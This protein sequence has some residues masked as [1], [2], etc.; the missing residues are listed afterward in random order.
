MRFSQKIT[1]KNKMKSKKKSTL[2]FSQTKNRS[3]ET[4]KTKKIGNLIYEIEKFLA[5]KVEN[6][7]FSTKYILSEILQIPV[8][9]L[10]FQ[11]EKTVSQQ[12]IKKIISAA[13]RRSKD[14]PLQYI[15]GKAYFRNLILKVGSG[16]LIPRPE[17][18]LMVDE[19]LSA[20]PQ[21]GTFCDIGTGS[22]AI[23]LS[24]AS[25]RPD[26]K[27]FAS[28]ISTNALKY[29]RYNRKKLKLKNVFIRQGSLFNPFKN[30]E[31]DVI[32][33]NLPYIKN[34]DIPKLPCEI[35]KFEPESAL[36]G[37]EDG[38]DLIRQFFI[39]AIAHSK[40][41]TFIIAEI[42]PEQ[43]RAIKS[44]LKKIPQYSNL[45]IIKDLNDQN[46]FISIC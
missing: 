35:R 3:L 11:A 39:D 20:L 37:G 8:P 14:E 44:F 12:N 21:G 23:A 2:R 34:S 27:V 18:E 9:E 10:D 22:G 5:G 28:E 38:L 16:V 25:E 33:A 13:K 32:A 42:A 40:K 45:R 19:I 43:T 46:R 31:F 7:P 29:A 15:F 4:K 26:A 36:R 30:Q 1:A 41:N 6:P 24:V 17:T